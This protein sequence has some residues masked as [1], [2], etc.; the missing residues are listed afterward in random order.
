[1]GQLETALYNLALAA[2]TDLAILQ[3]LTAANLA[4]TTTNAMLTATNKALVDSA[5]K[6]CAAAGSGGPPAGTTGTAGNKKKPLPNG[7]CWMHRHKVYSTHSSATCVLE[8]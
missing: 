2:L 1:M 7:Y 6:A 8:E 5:I 3:Q 4:L